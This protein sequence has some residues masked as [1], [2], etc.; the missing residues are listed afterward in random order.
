VTQAV[1]ISFIPISLAAI[2][3]TA[4]IAGFILTYVSRE[5]AG[6][7]IPQVK[8]AFWRDLAISHFESF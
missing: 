7:G 8:A 5:A 4:L 2:V 6:G 3:S 1:G